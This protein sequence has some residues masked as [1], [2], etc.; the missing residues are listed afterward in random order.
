[1][2]A[3][4]RRPKSSNFG[5]LS[6]TIFA[7]GLLV[8]VGGSLWLAK[9]DHL[10]FFGAPKKV[11]VKKK[12]PPKPKPLPS[13]I[14]L[15]V[16]PQAQ[17]PQL[18]NGCEVTSLSMLLSFVGHPVSKMTLAR[19]II[20]DPTKEVVSTYKIAS[21]QQVTQILK[22]GDPNVGFVG[23]IY[24]PG[25]GYGVYNKPLAKLANKILPRKVVNLT[26]QPFAD[27]LAAVGRGKPVI[28]WTTLD[29]KPTNA[30]ISWQSPEGKIIATP[31]ENAVVIAGYDK[32]TNVLYVANPGT[33]QMQTV[34][35]A[36]FVAS[37]HQLGRQA[38]TVNVPVHHTK[39]KKKAG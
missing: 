6:W 25:K 7:L 16:T 18:A 23:N 38:L 13:K 8:V 4:P 17:N 21:G 26:G 29:L 33:G 10:V 35:M 1:M 36:P 32:T 20:K 27:I 28:A 2:K 14:L 3:K 24:Q 39:T 11:A 19:E 12:A 31:L 22:W 5:K 9:K 34:A 30:W 37:W 15:K